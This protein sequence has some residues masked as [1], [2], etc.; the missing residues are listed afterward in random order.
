MG[1]TAEQAETRNR[2]GCATMLCEMRVKAAFR[3]LSRTTPPIPLLP[4]LL[5]LDKTE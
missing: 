3:Q 1:V 2:D 5:H 4:S